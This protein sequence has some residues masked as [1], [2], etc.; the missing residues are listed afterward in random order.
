MI[1]YIPPRKKQWKPGAR[2]SPFVL[3]ELMTL[4]LVYAVCIGFMLIMA[5]FFVG[6]AAESSRRS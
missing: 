4:P 1:A 6:G 2:A 5:F 3:L